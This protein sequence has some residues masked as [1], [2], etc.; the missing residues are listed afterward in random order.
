MGI[1]CLSNWPNNL[2]SSS[3][4]VNSVEEFFLKL[5]CCGKN[6]LFVTK[7]SLNWSNIT[8][9]DTLEMTGN[10]EIGL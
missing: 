7:D 4:A 5:F 8:F 1:L 2:S 6:K 10:T 3:R 9:S